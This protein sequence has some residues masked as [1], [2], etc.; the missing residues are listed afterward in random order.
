MIRRHTNRFK[1]Q[2]L[3]RMIGLVL[4]LELIGMTDS[5]CEPPLVVVVRQDS[6]IGQLRREEVAALFLGKR[7]TLLDQDVTPLD[8]HEASWREQFYQAVAD[9][10][11]IRV[12]AYWSR[13]V[14]S[15]QG[16]PPQELATSE[17]LTRLAN[18]PGVLIYLPVNQVGSSM[19]IVFKIQ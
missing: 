15:G 13:I 16:R 17:A 2:N 1:H 5:L 12:K 19:K 4:L 14:F 6:P 10:N 11:T 8:N 9:M 18:D 7:K 3:G